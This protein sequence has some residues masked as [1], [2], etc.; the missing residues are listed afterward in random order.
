MKIGQVELKKKLGHPLFT[1]M[2]IQG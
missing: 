2:S 1:T